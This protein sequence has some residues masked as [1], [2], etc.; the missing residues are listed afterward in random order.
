MLPNF[1]KTKEKLRR[2][3]DYTLKQ[4]ILSHLVPIDDIPESISF[5]G[6]KTITVYE[7]GSVSETDPKEIDVKLEI[8]LEDVETMTHEMVLDIIDQ[9]AQKIAREQKELFYEEIGRFAEEVGNVISGDGNSLSIDMLYQ[10]LERIPRDFDKDGNP[11]ELRVAVSP[12][13]FPSIANIISQ[14]EA[15][16]RFHALI[17]EKKEEWRARESNRKLVG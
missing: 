2:K 1:L 15:D 16:P 12:S 3:L 7:D 10:M 5:E 9:L 13:L 11:T 6:S 17:E 4:A 8:N 14:A